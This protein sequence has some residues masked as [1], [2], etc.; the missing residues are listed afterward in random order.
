MSVT[1]RD[2]GLLESVL[3]LDEIQACRA[4]CEYFVSEYVHI[5]DL[6]TGTPLPFRLWPD[7]R[8]ALQTFIRERLTIV[9]KARQL[10]FTWLALAL[11]V[12]YML[13]R[14]GFRVVCLSR[15]E[16]EAK[17]LVRRADFIL[18]H[19]PEWLLLP[20][21]KP[22]G[23][24]P[25]Y[26]ATTERIV[27][28][29][30]A[31]EDSSLL[32]FPA[33]QD[34]GRTFTASLVIIDEWAFQQWARE[35]W[36][37][38]YPIINRPTGGKVIGLSTGKRGTFFEEMWQ[39][40]KA[41]LNGFYPVFYSWRADPRRDDAWYEATKRDLPHRHKQEYP[42]S[43]ADAFAAGEGAAFSEF[44]ETIHVIDDPH[45]YPPDGWTIVRAYDSGYVTRACCKW[46]AISYDGWVVCYREYYPTQVTDAD[47][48]AE[49]RRL[50]VRPDGTPERI[51]KT[52]ADPA[53]WQKRSNTGQS[54]ADIFAANGIPFEPASND[55][56]NGWRRLHEWL[57]PF[58]GPDGQKMAMLRFTRACANTIRT[59]PALTVDKNRPEDVDTDCED[60][61]ADCDRY[62]V[63]SRPQPPVP[64]EEQAR[65]RRARQKQIQ[66]RVSRLT[67]Y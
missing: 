46:Y 10:G 43:E 9:L 27:I 32:S 47:Q 8:E 20:G 40:A 6:D 19:L 14:P 63:L 11:A 13:F 45:W 34:S 51:L 56:I 38:A 29:H 1:A 35:I 49:I 33:A 16:D 61:P 65:R 2:T 26:E 37:A 31:G 21:R 28:H 36:A 7:Q 12:W 23:I 5:E 42:A 64:K 54:T 66:P 55:R 4:D 57:K 67:G 44:D 24:I 48:A 41:G 22:G 59:Y 50:S 30:P 17:E 62:F 25:A 60:H 52:V 18:A 15:G 39:K 58:E 3:I 53:C